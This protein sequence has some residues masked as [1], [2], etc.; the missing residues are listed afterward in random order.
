MALYARIKRDGEPLKMPFGWGL[1][2]LNAIY[3]VNDNEDGNISSSGS[4][5]VQNRWT[6]EDPSDGEV[7][8]LEPGDVLEMW[9]Q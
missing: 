4:H 6:F 1:F 9:R 2:H 5:V 3:E 7:L 8:V